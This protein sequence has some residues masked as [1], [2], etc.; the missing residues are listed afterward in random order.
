MICV[1][2]IIASLASI[3]YPVM[4]QAK[5]SSYRTACLGNLRQLGQ[6]CEL[7]MGDNDDHYP[8]GINAVE[9]VAPHFYLGRDKSQDPRLFPL[10]TDALLSSQPS[11]AGSLRCPSDTGRHFLSDDVTLTPLFPSNAGSSYI[12][13]DLLQGQSSSFWPDP[14]G[15]VWSADASGDWHLKS[16]PLAGYGLVNVLAYDWHVSSRSDAQ[17]LRMYPSWTP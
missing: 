10:I 4:I 2:V 8:Y 3:L 12:F 6:G 16:V 1:I 14:A 13:A 17:G 9:R 11:L 15:S 7:Y 5:R